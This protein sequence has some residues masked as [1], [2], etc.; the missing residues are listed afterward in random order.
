MRV[1][2]MYL[3]IS[4]IICTLLKFISADSEQKARELN[5]ESDLKL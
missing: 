3:T 5:S 1:R 2:K 4:I